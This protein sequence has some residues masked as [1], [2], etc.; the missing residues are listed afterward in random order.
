MEES[1]RHVTV[2]LSLFLSGEKQENP[3]KK[4]PQSTYLNEIR[5]GKL[6]NTSKECYRYVT[7]LC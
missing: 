6:Q 3:Q 5:A 4:I 2:V 1:D 7:P